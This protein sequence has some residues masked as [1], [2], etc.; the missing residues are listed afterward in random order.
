MST[1]HT[2]AACGLVL[3]LAVSSVIAAVMIGWAECGKACGAAEKQ[4]QTTD[5]PRGAR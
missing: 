2:E 3:M 4:A 1:E 5:R